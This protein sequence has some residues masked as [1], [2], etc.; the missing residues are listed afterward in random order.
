LNSLNHFLFSAKQTNPSQHASVLPLFCAM[1]YFLDIS[2]KGTNYSGWQ[3]QGNANT[4][5]DELNKTL[6]T[7]LRTEIETMGSG[8]TDAGVH[9]HHQIAHFDTDKIK[10][11]DKFIYKVNA[12]LPKDIAINKLLPVK[13]D[14][15]ARFDADSRSYQYFI[16]TYKDAFNQN[17]S[18]FF[19]AELDFKPIHEAIELIKSWKDFEAFSKVHTEVNHFNCDIFEA[20][21]EPTAVG[22]VLYI[23]ANRFLRGMVRTIVG[24]L[25]DIGTGKTSVADLEEILKSNNRQK[26]GRALSPDGL[27]LH[28]IT[29]PKDIYL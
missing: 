4:V 8:R 26:A 7:L 21:W 24:T 6:S 1:R 18:H 9:A 28:A 5:Q 16:H 29:Y 13:E 25:L 22:Y 23:R 15:H 20:H 10:N 19:S 14:A 2:Y 27:Y 12:L 3:I 17:T 11:T